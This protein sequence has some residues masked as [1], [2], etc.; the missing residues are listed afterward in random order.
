[1]ARMTSD[2]MA[3]GG[4][5]KA[6]SDYMEGALENQRRVP[7]IQAQ[8]Q[9]LGQAQRGEAV[10]MAKLP[11]E[12]QAAQT[13]Q[14]S[15]QMKM[16]EQQRNILRM[17]QFQKEVAGMGN[18]DPSTPEGRQRWATIAMKYVD[19]VPEFRTILGQ[20]AST[21][22]ENMDQ[23]AAEIAKNGPKNPQQAE[24][25]NNYMKYRWQDPANA[26]LDTALAALLR[27]QAAQTAAD[28]KGATTQ[29]TLP[30]IQAEVTKRMQFIIPK[31]LAL[32]MGV[33]PAQRFVQDYILY[34][35][36]QDDP[37][38]EQ[39]LGRKVPLPPM[40]KELKDKY[41]TSKDWSGWW[42]GKKDTPTPE[43]LQDFP[44]YANQPQQA[45]TTPAA[46]PKPG[47]AAPQKSEQLKEGDWQEIVPG[48]RFRIKK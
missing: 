5:S 30:K 27:A 7:Q 18:T 48:V 19:I 10:E 41:Y 24:F 40:P 37:S 36:A 15:E 26:K 4:I 35:L 28:K 29:W 46:P 39:V 25:Y 42:A 38:I 14:Q 47:A 34:T 2:E 31:A 20:Y 1:M 17:Q 21:K 16:A 33:L 6:I 11:M 13:K 12:M 22:Y 43:L 32:G 3:F 9:Q 8:A 44:E 23:V 45:P